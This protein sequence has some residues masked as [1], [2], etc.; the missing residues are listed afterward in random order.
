MLNSIAVFI[1]FCRLPETPF[2]GKF[3]PKDQ[4]CQFKLKFGIET[5]SNM[6]NSM[7]VFTPY[8]FGLKLFSKYYSEF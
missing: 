6:R 8:T 7:V 5:N 4:I 1:V 3:G 2:L